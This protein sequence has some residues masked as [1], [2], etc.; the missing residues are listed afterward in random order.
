[1]LPDE[2]S[3]GSSSSPIKDNFPVIRK[4]ERK[5]FGAFEARRDLSDS[6]LA[7]SV[8]A[9]P[10]LKRLL[11]FRQRLEQIGDQAVIGDLE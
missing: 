10:V 1:M 5:A 4:C 6:L 9:R 2:G 3:P 7:L 11:Q 8:L